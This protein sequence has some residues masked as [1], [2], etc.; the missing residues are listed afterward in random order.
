MVRPFTACIQAHPA[1]VPAL[2]ATMRTFRMISGT[3]LSA[4]QVAPVDFW[5][6]PFSRLRGRNFR[7]KRTVFAACRRDGTFGA[8]SSTAGFCRRGQVGSFCFCGGI[9]PKFRAGVTAVGCWMRTSFGVPTAAVPR[10]RGLGVR[11]KARNEGECLNL[12]A[13]PTLYDFATHGV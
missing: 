12:P 4:R 2:A 11:V 3:I 6:L 9:G 8:S 7:I 5:P 1:P 10:G 13:S